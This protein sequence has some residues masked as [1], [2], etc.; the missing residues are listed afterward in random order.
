MI[1]N[2]YEF[3][4]CY[5]QIQLDPQIDQYKRSVYSLLDAVGTVGGVFGIVWSVTGII[6]GIVIDKIFVYYLK[7]KRQAVF[8]N[9]MF[10]YD[11]FQQN[12]VQVDEVVNQNLEEQNSINK[13]D[14]IEENQRK[15]EQ[16]EINEEQ[17]NSRAKM[18][19]SSNKAN[20]PYK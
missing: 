8:N 13:I 17:N 1:F 12:E 11:P 6:M 4:K 3:F 16:N 9:G 7:Q 2:L 5:V 19:L 10:S 15:D 14:N 18:Y 20:I